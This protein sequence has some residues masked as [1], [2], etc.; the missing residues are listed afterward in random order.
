MLPGFCAVDVAGEIDLRADDERY[1]ERSL[2]S[3]IMQRMRGSPSIISILM[4]AGTVGSDL[5]RRSVREQADFL[6]EP[7]LDRQC[8]E[9]GRNRR[10][11]VTAV[12]RGFS[13]LRQ[14]RRA[15]LSALSA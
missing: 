11:G 12:S 6:F 15:Q 5:Q 4:R 1:G 9:P 10:N 13:I 8:V 7:P 3:L 14:R 2:A